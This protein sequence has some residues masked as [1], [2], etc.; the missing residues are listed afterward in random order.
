MGTG[1][2]NAFVSLVD[3]SGNS[4]TDASGRVLVASDGVLSVTTSI[5]RIRSAWRM[6]VV[7]VVVQW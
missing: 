6:G 5:T 1:T 2:V 4:V 7:M 3:A